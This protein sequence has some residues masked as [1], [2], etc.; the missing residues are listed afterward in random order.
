MRLN[1]RSCL[2][3]IKVRSKAASADVAAAVSWLHET[4]FNIN[5]IYL[6]RRKKLSK[7]FIPREEKSM[8]D[9]KASLI[10]N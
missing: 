9:F 2:Y 1:E 5:K 3:N 7:A 6:Y 10:R 4:T 8:P